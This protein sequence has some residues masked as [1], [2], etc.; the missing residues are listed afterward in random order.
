MRTK[1]KL[2]VAGIVVLA[3]IV[4][5]YFVYQSMTGYT[6]YQPQVSKF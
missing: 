3:A 2:A 5:G 1:V 4:A 6:V